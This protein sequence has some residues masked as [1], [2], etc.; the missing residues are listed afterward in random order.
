MTRD[1]RE[2]G[3]GLR[4]LEELREGGNECSETGCGGCE[5]SGGGEVVIRRDAQGPLRQLDYELRASSEVVECVSFQQVGPGKRS[6]RKPTGLGRT[7]QNR[8]VPTVGRVESDFSSSARRA[9]ISRI[10]V[11]SRPPSLIT[12]S[13]PFNH[14]L[15]PASKDGS[16]R[17]VVVE[18]RWSWSRVTERDELV[19]RIREVSRLPQYLAS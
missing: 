9:L 1:T 11:C 16:H 2:L 5:T 14:S 7:S 10:Q 19:G 13:F 12:S 4:E 8:N 3:W 6:P 18:R 15:S 17:E